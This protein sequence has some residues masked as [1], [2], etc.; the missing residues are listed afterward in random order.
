LIDDEE[1]REGLT[2]V[3]NICIEKGYE[4]KEKYLEKVFNID[5]Y[6]VSKNLYNRVKGGYFD[7]EMFLNIVTLGLKLNEIEWTKK[8]IEKYNSKLAPDTRQDAYNYC[9]A[10]FY[11]KIRNF[12]EALKSIAKVAYADLHMK[13]NVRITTITILYELNKIEEVLTQIENF[14]KYIQN[15]KLLN[16]GHK[17]ISSNFIKFTAALCK[18]KY[19]SLAN[20]DELQKSITEANQVSH[21]TWLLNKTNELIELRKGLGSN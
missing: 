10:K 15:D 19:S 8:F 6:L 18:A 7:N 11:F 16:A 13:I 14:R 5:K 20:I 17:R 3:G 9:Y 4:G 1:R 12:D 2:I 21:R